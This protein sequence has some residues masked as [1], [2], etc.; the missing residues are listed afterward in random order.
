VAEELGIC[1]LVFSWFVWAG[2]LLFS[3]NVCVSFLGFERLWAEAL[4]DMYV[5]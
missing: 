1:F 3:I 4:V 2:L 5:V